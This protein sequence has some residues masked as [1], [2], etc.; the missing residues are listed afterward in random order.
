MARSLDAPGLAKI[1]TTSTPVRGLADERLYLGQAETRQKRDS[2]EIQ[3][4]D[5]PALILTGLVERDAPIEQIAGVG[6]AVA[7]R[8]TERVEC[9]LAFVYGDRREGH[10]QAVVQSDPDDRHRA[11]DVIESDRQQ[12]GRVEVHARARVA[13]IDALCV[14]VLASVRIEVETRLARVLALDVSVSV[15]LVAAAA[16]SSRARD[17]IVG[18]NDVDQI[19]E[20]SSDRAAE[21]LCPAGVR[22]NA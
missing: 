10:G 5:L 16:S 8:Q 17:E 21:E 18:A 2:W 22:R 13:G 3:G 19:E 14:A 6:V 9:G 11:R 20:H 15:R 1:T 7:E 4:V 12:L